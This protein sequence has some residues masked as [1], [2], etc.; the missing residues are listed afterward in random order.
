MFDRSQPPHNDQSAASREEEKKTKQSSSGK[1]RRVLANMS[2][3]KRNYTDV[4]LQTPD[5]PV[6]RGEECGRERAREEKT[7]ESG[8]APEPST[9]AYERETMASRVPGNGSASL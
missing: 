9:P 6:Q 8:E 3:R 5:A 1:A 4:T 7:D 2:E